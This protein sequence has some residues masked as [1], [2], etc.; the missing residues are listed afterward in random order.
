MRNKIVSLVLVF[1]MVF[2]LAAPVFA[3]P[4]GSDDNPD[5]SREV[6]RDIV[7]GQAGSLGGLVS[8]ILPADVIKAF[9]KSAISGLLDLGS[10]GDMAGGALGGLL[11]GAISGAIG[12]DLPDSVNLGGIINDVL[13]NE[14]IAGIITSDFVS[15]IIDKTIDN[16][17]DALVIEDVINVV[18]EGMVDQLTDELWNDGEPTCGS[19]GFGSFGIQTGVWNT[20]GGWNEVNIG[21]AL[22]TRLGGSALSGDIESY[23]SNID[24]TRIFSID[25]I[26]GAVKDAVV[27]TA[28][29][30]YETY[31]PILIAR[32]KALVE[33]KIEEIKEQAKAELIAAL[34]G[35]FADLKLTVRDGLEEVEGKVILHIRES[36]AY[37]EANRDRILHELIEL[38]RIVNFADKYAC[39]DLGKVNAI[40]E[41]IIKCL[42]EKPP[43][44]DP[45]LVCANATAFVEKLSGN[46]NTLTITIVEVYS[47]GAIVFIEAEFAIDNN[48]AAKYAVGEYKVYVDTKGNTQIRECYIA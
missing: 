29:E 24:F 5:F 12:V 41:K 48:A 3:A 23:F 17:I 6:L 10:I 18:T 40:L 46:K 4:P 38:Q 27:D 19:F 14:I 43:V 32:A 25:V 45:V 37:V 42:E 15:S 7:E 36:R 31:K 1:M 9:A 30:Y 21:I 34:N 33:A 39:L 47:D 2:S 11:E 20:T 22:F 16:L 13:A 28:T 44:V 26:L 8:T 35:I